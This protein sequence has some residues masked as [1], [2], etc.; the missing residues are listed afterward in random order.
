MKISQVAAQLFT[1]R[2]HCK[3][4]TDLAV[5]LKKIAGIGYP[6][7]QLSGLGPIP[8]QEIVALCQQNGLTI[9][10]THEGG[11]MICDE[12]QQV[13]TKLKK[14]GCRHTAYPYPGG[15]KFESF[16]EVKAL[17]AKLNAAGKVLAAAG[18]TL[19]Y[20]NHHI[21]F[22]KVAG[23]T[24]LEWIYE[25]TD[26]RYLQGEP[27]TYWIQTGGGEPTD[28]CHRLQGRLPLL[29]MKDYL[30]TA[31]E[32]K[33]AMAEIGNGNLNWKSIVQA[34]EVAGC[35]WFIV[36]QDTCPADPF[37]SLKQSFD[38]IKANLCN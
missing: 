2:D 15:I 26:A 10:A 22:R 29:H 24:I 23:K 19:S 8:E 3:T 16:D 13:V 5:T 1:V 28:W 11:Q 9:C 33:I 31:P 32:N 14:L 4:A 7:V 6:A 20:H 17:A 27:D 18:Q 12:P 34:A 25:L 38:Y 35:E 37:D 21:E 36:E 30:V